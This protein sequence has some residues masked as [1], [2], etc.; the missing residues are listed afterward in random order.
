M[1][2]KPPVELFE[3]YLRARGHNVTKTRRRIVQAVFSLHGHFDAAELWQALRDQKV[4][5]ATVYRTLDL[6]EQ[7]GFVRRVSFGEAHAHY[8]H[9]LERDDHGHLVCRRCGEVVEFSGARI[10]D[11]LADVAA[12]HDFQLQEGVVQGFGLCRRCRELE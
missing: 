4:S 6:L 8:E 9:V 12:R 10:R 1:T 2:T 3:A 5:M 11:L 7:A